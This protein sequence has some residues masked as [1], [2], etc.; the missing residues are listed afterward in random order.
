M[1]TQAP[2]TSSPSTSA[3]NYKLSFGDYSISDNNNIQYRIYNITSFSSD[4]QIFNNDEQITGSSVF[5]IQVNTVYPNG[6]DPISNNNYVV[7]AKKCQTS[8][9][10]VTQNG[11]TST[12]NYGDTVTVF[13]DTTI[14]PKIN[15]LS[16]K[17]T[18]GYFVFENNKQLNVSTAYPKLYNYYCIDY[19]DYY[20]FAYNSTIIPTDCTIYEMCIYPSVE[21]LLYRTYISISYDSNSYY[22]GILYEASLYNSD[23]GKTLGSLASGWSYN[24][25]DKVSNKHIAEIYTYAHVLAPTNNT[26]DYGFEDIYTKFEIKPYSY[27]RFK[28]PTAINRYEQCVDVAS[29]FSNDG[30]STYVQNGS[31]DMA[32]S[33]SK[34]GTTEIFTSMP[35]KCVVYGSPAYLKVSIVPSPNG[36]SDEDYITNV[37]IHA[38]EGNTFKGTKTMDATKYST[39]KYE[40]IQKEK[41][42]TFTFDVTTRVPKLNI[43]KKYSEASVVSSW[44]FNGGALS[45]TLTTDNNGQASSDISNIKSDYA[46]IMAKSLSISEAYRYL[47]PK[48]IFFQSNDFDT[49]TVT[50]KTDGTGNDYRSFTYYI[51]GNNIKQYNYDI[52]A[53]ALWIE[54]DHLITYVTPNGGAWYQNVPDFSFCIFTSSS[55][56]T[57]FLYKG[58]SSATQYTNYA[59]ITSLKVSKSVTV[60]PEASGYAYIGN[61]TVSRAVKGGSSKTKLFSFT[62]V[63]NSP[64]YVAAVSENTIPDTSYVTYIDAEVCAY[65]YPICFSTDS[66]G[67]Y[68]V[69]VNNQTVKV[70][71]FDITKTITP[72]TYAET[73]NLAW[74]TPDNNKYELKN[75]SIY[76]YK[77]DNRDY[78]GSHSEN[79]LAN[80]L[81]ANTDYKLVN[82][83]SAYSNTINPCDLFVISPVWQVTAAPKSV[84]IT[85]KAVGKEY[86]ITIGG[87]NKH[88][89]SS[90]VV[91]TS[92]LETES[93]TMGTV[94]PTERQY[95]WNSGSST[96]AYTNTGGT[97]VT[98]TGIKENDAIK[99][100]SDLSGSLSKVVIT[101]AFSDKTTFSVSFQRY[102]QTDGTWMTAPN[103]SSIK[104]CDCYISGSSALTSGAN[105]ISLDTLLPSGDTFGIESITLDSNKYEITKIQS[106]VDGGKTWTDRA[107]GK[108][109]AWKITANTTVMP[110]VKQTD[111]EMH[112]NFLPVAESDYTVVYSVNGVERS[113]LYVG[114]GSS[115]VSTVTFQSSSK[116]IFKSITFDSV[117]YSVNSIII[118]NTNYSL[119][120]EYQFY[121]PN[122]NYFD[123]KVTAKADYSKINYKLNINAQSWTDNISGHFLYDVILSDEYFKL[124]TEKPAGAHA[125]T[126]SYV[127]I[128]SSEYNNVNT[129]T[130]PVTY[131][132]GGVPTSPNVDIMFY[133]DTVSYNYKIKSSGYSP[134]TASY[135]KSDNYNWTVPVSKAFELNS[136]KSI[137][138]IVQ[139]SATKY[140]FR[141]E[142]VPYD[143]KNQ[144]SF[145]NNSTSFGLKPGEK[146]TYT[147]ADPATVGISPENYGIMVSKSQINVNNTWQNCKYKLALS[148]TAI[149][150]EKSY[151]TLSIFDHNNFNNPMY[152]VSVKV[153]GVNA[154]GNKNN[155]AVLTYLTQISIPY[156]LH[157]P[158]KTT[159]S[160]TI[161]QNSVAYYNKFCLS[162]NKEGSDYFA[163]SDT[164]TGVLQ[165]NLDV[166]PNSSITT[167]FFIKYI[168]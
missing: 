152:K 8:D 86:D 114:K 96:I 10:N 108:T 48:Q 161:T 140:D 104:W 165:Y 75:Y 124:E 21:D 60:Q 123:V 144:K 32:S 57:E 11:K 83:L 121:N 151:A 55:Y 81:K 74:A 133:V 25:P 102:K 70:T 33:V 134:Y 91:V 139:V 168:V 141:G 22:D 99:Q 117:E 7:S 82:L 42:Y 100:P 34:S 2:S 106:T 126:A 77:Y 98:K 65:H 136:Q 17:Y 54:N 68:T 156:K 27:T 146:T 67:Q 50:F 142:L 18:V 78:T 125:I 105:W 9:F 115:G 43:V 128:D 147:L 64:E 167:T 148:P 166:A 110:V 15:T 73:V 122:A 129:M 19:N 61:V 95:S 14:T 90:D 20:K 119:N 1:A 16:P 137:S 29:Y 155:E 59:Y 66:I 40:Y 97:T 39:Y 41:A 47:T 76:A 5:T 6:G 101:P 145:I 72:I 153:N 3:T 49:Q 13:S 62:A 63:P 116:I 84:T 87:A 138:Y 154:F 35:D 51:G 80:G 112:L 143:V 162:E 94:K 88:V 111:K 31:I 30:G 103:Y 46:V 12:L 158:N 157:N 23:T 79:V 109:N 37:N 127:T 93:V 4:N 150:I 44:S 92:M 24:Y 28:Y 107:F 52:T 38:Y 26:Y 163:I 36:K 160:I 113:Q 120:N 132:G 45:K 69:N 135:T 118:N 85:S 164:T 56:Q 58:N 89:S 130:I 131:T 159:I 53:Y 149:P 71:G